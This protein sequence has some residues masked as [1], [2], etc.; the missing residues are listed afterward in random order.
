MDIQCQSRKSIQINVKFKPR[1]SQRLIKIVDNNAEITEPKLVADAFNNYFANIVKMLENETRS[2]PNSPMI[3]L[4]NPTCN[5][6][7]GL[8][9]EMHTDP[10]SEA[11][12][13]CQSVSGSL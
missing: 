2:A 9:H 8:M 7:L 6:F 11:D 3:Y 1:S 5:S 12:L 10:K 4:N 13:D